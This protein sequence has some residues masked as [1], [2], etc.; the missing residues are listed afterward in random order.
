MNLNQT[1]FA[2]EDKEYGGIF[3]RNLFVGLYTIEATIITD[4][5]TV[6]TPPIHENPFANR[7]INPGVYN[8]IQDLTFSRHDLG[9]K[10]VTDN[11]L[12]YGILQTIK[13]I[14]N[15]FIQSSIRYQIAA[16]ENDLVVKN[17]LY[18]FATILT[19]MTAFFTVG[20]IANKIADEAYKLNYVAHSYLALFSSYL[21]FSSYN[22]YF[23]PKTKAVFLDFGSLGSVTA[24][25]TLSYLVPFSMH[26][27]GI[28]KGGELEP[29]PVQL[30]KGSVL[31]ASYITTGTI[32][33]PTAMFVAEK[34][35]LPEG[36]V[37]NFLEEFS[38]Y[39]LFG[40][41]SLT[42]SGLTLAATAAI[43]SGDAPILA[44]TRI[45]A[46]MLAK[47][48]AV[49]GVE[50]AYDNKEVICENAW[51]EPICKYLGVIELSEV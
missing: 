15:L 45:A 16:P 26:Q 22:N 33:V 51:I 47:A 18:N 25:L 9:N 19:G 39:E 1:C 49:T 42:A 6:N 3:V 13:Y 12:F 5:L 43:V 21:L 10:N 28:D 8:G 2:L 7:L 35:L 41:S 11:V 29:T 36:L 38:Q 44:L 23:D 31:V 20:G 50:I 30:F 24:G 34:L 32:A 48:T 17:V 40:V 27:I 37:T 14:P 4:A 46:F